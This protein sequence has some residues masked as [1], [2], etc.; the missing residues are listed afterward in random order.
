VRTFQVRKEDA[1]ALRRWY[2]VDAAGKP[3]G[4]VASMVAWL[5]QGKH[6]PEYTP[7]V[8]VGDHV[9]VINAGK[10]VLTGRKAERKIYYR[11][12]GYPGG[13]K[14]VPYGELLATRPEFVIKL[15]VRR[16]MP[17]TKLGRR[18]FKKLRVYRGAEHPHRAQRPVLWEGEQ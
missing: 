5:L 15:A 16:M 4:R 2:I 3:L 7:H 14:A 6:K 11:H 8:D 17:R 10:V 13:L 12:S 1:P 18:M 9:I